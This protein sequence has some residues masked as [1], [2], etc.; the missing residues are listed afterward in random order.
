MEIPQ[1]T[2]DDVLIL[3]PAGRMTI[4]EAD[5]ALKQAVA[6]A[7]EANEIGRASCRERV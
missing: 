3:E 2:S 6:S 4:G 1:R 7:A 5:Y